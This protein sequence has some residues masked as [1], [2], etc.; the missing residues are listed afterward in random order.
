LSEKD[1]PLPAAAYS[2]AMLLWTEGQQFS[3]AELAE[4]LAESGFTDIEVEPTI[5]FWSVVTGRK[6][7]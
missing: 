7:Y 5:G 1:G 3:G 4:M 2:V 6:P